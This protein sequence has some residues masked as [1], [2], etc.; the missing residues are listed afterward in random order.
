MPRTEGDKIHRGDPILVNWQAFLLALLLF[1]FFL[2]LTI[3]A[4]LALPGSL[5]L[6]STGKA[7][8]I[9]A[10]VPSGVTIGNTPASRAIVLET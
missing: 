8:T 10:S 7:I 5:G 4:P 1:I 6:R 2:R 9:D 3:F